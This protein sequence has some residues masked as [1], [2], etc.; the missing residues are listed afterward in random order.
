MCGRMIVQVDGVSYYHQFSSQ[1][2]GWE[3]VVAPDAYQ[4]LGPRQDAREVRPTESVILHRVRDGELRPDPA[5]WTLVPPWTESVADLRPTREGPR[6]VPPP[7][8]HFNSRRDTLLKSPGWRRLLSTQRGVLLA[9]AFL[10]WSDEELLAGGGKRAGRYRLSRDRLMP[11]AC[12]WNDV[13][14]GGR[15]VATCSV[16]TVPPNELLASLPHHRM[17]A[18]LLGERLGAWLDPRTPDPER[19]LQTTLGEEF[20]A[21][22]LPADRYGE[23]VPQTPP[24]GAKLRRPKVSPKTPDKPS[25]PDLFG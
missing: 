6:L 17:P 20:E 2:N 21:T 15:T 5:F 3:F 7:R 13:V 24:G 4:D 19:C 23:L 10:E 11:L 1:E 8:T 12:V 25:L 22:V 18:V 16:V 9:D 14:V